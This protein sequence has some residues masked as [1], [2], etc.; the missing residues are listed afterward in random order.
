MLG[1]LNRGPAVIIHPQPLE[2]LMS[3]GWP[4]ALVVD[5]N[6]GCMTEVTSLL[7][8]KL[9]FDVVQ[10]GDGV[11]A[12][13][14]F[15]RVKNTLDLVVTDLN[16]GGGKKNGDV[17]LRR[18]REVSPNTPTVLFTDDGV[19]IGENP[20]IADAA[21]EKTV[22]LSYSMPEFEQAIKKVTKL[23]N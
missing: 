18:I 9:G 11:E 19:F 3:K 17:L 6:R 2:N 12:F 16:M 7:T 5:D 23:K 22:D 14:I 4:R 13:E 1:K 10:A 15:D 21:V 20:D 8:D